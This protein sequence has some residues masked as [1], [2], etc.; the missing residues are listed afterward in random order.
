MPEATESAKDKVRSAYSKATTR[1]REAHKEEFNTL[2]AAEAKALG[3]EWKPRLSAE[4]KKR[5]A[6]REAIAADPE[7]AASILDDVVGVHP[8][9]TP[10]EVAR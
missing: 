4:E 1:L 9:D 5:A 6:L 8:A 10:P 7:L 2:M 3:V